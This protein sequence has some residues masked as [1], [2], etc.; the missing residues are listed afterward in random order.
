VIVKQA[1]LKKHWDLSKTLPG[2]ETWPLNSN[3]KRYMTRSYSYF[4]EQ[5]QILQIKDS[6]EINSWQ[7]P[8]SA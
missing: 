6:F 5:C 3:H 4:K 8:R 7:L 2:A 1:V